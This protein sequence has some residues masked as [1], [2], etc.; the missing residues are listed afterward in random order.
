[1][2]LSGIGWRRRVASL[3]RLGTLPVRN[4]LSRR[5]EI[6]QGRG[7]QGRGERYFVVYDGVDWERF[8]RAAG[9]APANN[10]GTEAANPA[11]GD[12]L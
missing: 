5:Q 3:I 6:R 12:E 11:E 2:T 8:D 7:Q 4:A 1:M 10:G 9:P